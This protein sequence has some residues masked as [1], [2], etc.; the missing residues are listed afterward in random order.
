MSHICPWEF[1]KLAFVIFVKPQSLLEFLFS[2]T[3]YIPTSHCTFPPLAWKPAISLRNSCSWRTVA[4]YIWKQRS[5][6]WY[7][8]CYSNVAALMPLRWTEQASRVHGHARACI[9]MQSSLAIYLS[10]SSIKIN[11]HTDFLNSIF[12][13][14]SLFRQRNQSSVFLIVFSLDLFFSM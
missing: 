12:V 9:H 1:F 5:R 2:D 10:L 7:V 8:Y 13:T 11:E 6:R 3:K 14:I 4:D